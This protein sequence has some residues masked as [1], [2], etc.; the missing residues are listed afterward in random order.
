MGLQFTFFENYVLRMFSTL[1]VNS[2][3]SHKHWYKLINIGD[4][5]KK[6]SIL[7][8]ILALKVVSTQ[9]VLVIILVIC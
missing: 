4:Y 1:E 2:I 9:Y 7:L 8:I 3:P 6:T 5:F